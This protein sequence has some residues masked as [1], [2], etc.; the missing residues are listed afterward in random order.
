MNN[1]ITLSIKEQIKVSISDEDLLDQIIKA[2]EFLNP[3]YIENEKKGRCNWQ[4]PRVIKTYFIVKGNHFFPCGYLPYLLE[5]LQEKDI[6]YEIQEHRVVQPVSY[7]PLKGIKF[8]EY[9]EKAIS[10]ALKADQGCI[11]SPTGSGKSLM[12]LELIR[13][14]GQKA[15]IIVHRNDLAKQWIDLIKDKLGLKA[16]YLGRGKWDI[17]KEITVATVQTLAKYKE[18][19][20]GNSFG[21][22]LT[23]ECHHVPAETFFSVIRSFSPRYRYGLSATVNRRDG[24]ERIIYRALGPP[25]ASI[26]KQEVEAVG[27]VV[28]VTCQLIETGFDPGIIKDWNDYLSA[29]SCNAER[30]QLIIKIAMNSNAPMLILCDRISHA[31]NLSAMLDLRNIKHVLAHGQVKNRDEIISLIKK[32]KLTIGTTSLLGEGLDIAHWGVLLLA[33]PISS[34][35]KLLQAI[36]RILRPNEGKLSALVYDLRDKC[37]FSGASF[38]KR[39]EIYRSRGIWV[40]FR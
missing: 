33:S 18:G 19:D 13:Q 39:Y 38:N 26:E 25:I 40:N 4:V 29:L 22:L 7:K 14:R 5:L 6:P 21:L 20:I 10:Q 32:S 34:E 37:G 27:A 11:I 2:N 3:R 8:R 23:D 30:N 12:G 9:Q 35:I 17:G 28:P 1:Q 16:G 31:Q 24:L 36:G 15:L